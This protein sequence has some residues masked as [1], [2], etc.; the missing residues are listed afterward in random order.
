MLRRMTQEPVTTAWGSQ[1]ANGGH[2]FD[3]AQ[4]A[5]DEM[6]EAGF[7]PEFGAGCGRADGGD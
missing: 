4:A 2:G 1:Q 5:L 7:R 6:H 3:L